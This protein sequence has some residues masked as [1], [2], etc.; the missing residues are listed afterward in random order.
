MV[1]ECVQRV[2]LMAI[3]GLLRE[4]L[5]LFLCSEEQ[6]ADRE[7]TTGTPII[8]FHGTNPFESKTFDIYSDGIKIMSVISMVQAFALLI[9]CYFVLNIAYPGKMI[10]T[11]TFLQK[12]ILNLQDSVKSVIQSLLC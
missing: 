11:L 1:S 2:A 12:V 6:H 3:P 4:D 10:K 9:G 8:V 5:E 7:E